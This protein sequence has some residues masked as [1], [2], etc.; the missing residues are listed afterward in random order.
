MQVWSDLK[1]NTKKKAQRIAI[2]DETPGAH[3][4]S[5]KLALSSLEQEV[6]KIAGYNGSP[7]TNG[8]V[9]RNNVPN[10]NEIRASTSNGDNVNVDVVIITMFMYI[11]HI[12]A[13]KWY[14]Y[15]NK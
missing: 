13:Y 8:V 9:I 6:L 5:A 3:G 11:H 2:R 1:N 7:A 14:I 15:Y 12:H 4:P 10:G